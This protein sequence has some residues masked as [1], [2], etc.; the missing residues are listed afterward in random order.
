MSERKAS[1]RAFLTTV[2]MSATASLPLVALLSGCAT[3]GLVSYRLRMES[4]RTVIT[5][6]EYAELNE[7]G[8]A[9][10]LDVEGFSDPV[11]VLRKET[12]FLALSPICT[13]L[14]CTVRKES[15]Y[16]R[17]PCHGST[18]SLEGNVV[19][20][21]AEKPLTVFRTEM[22]GDKLYIQL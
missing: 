11:I 10:E 5:P 3:T 13:H 1:R 17:C 18:Y 16:L 8:G 4:R 14:G 22:A 2:A 15:S 12:G 9:I 7:P 19:R 21:P 20:G 6:S